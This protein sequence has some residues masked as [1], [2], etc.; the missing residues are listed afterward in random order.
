M[1]ADGPVPSVPVDLQPL[2]QLLLPIHSSP[3]PQGHLPQK[4]Q[5]IA[6]KHGAELVNYVEPGTGQ[7]PLS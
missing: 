5:Q 7:H 6:H 4:A 1:H 3:L 2:Q